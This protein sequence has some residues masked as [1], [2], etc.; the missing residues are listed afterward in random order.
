[1]GTASALV[2]E[3]S[4]QEGRVQVHRVT[5]A[6]DPGLVIN[7]DGAR[8]QVQGSVMMALSSALHEE[9][10]IQDG[11]VVESNFDRYRLLPMRDA[12]PVEVLLVESGDEPQGMGE[13]VM[14]PAAAAVANAVFTL[15]GERLRTL[16]LRPRQG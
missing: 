4:V 6:A 13:P 12:P 14:G 8:L 1:L 11:R 16:P 7:P 9:L 15:T 3:V 10:T 5:V 2:A